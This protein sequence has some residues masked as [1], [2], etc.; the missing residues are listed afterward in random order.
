MG[1]PP[2]T[3]PRPRGLQALALILP[4]AARHR[5]VDCLPVGVVVRR[6]GEEGV[7]ERLRRR[8]PNASVDPHVVNTFVVTAPSFPSRRGL[9]L[10]LDFAKDSRHELRGECLRD[11]SVVEGLSQRRHLSVHAHAR[12]E[13]NLDAQGFKGAARGDRRGRARLAHAVPEERGEDGERRGDERG[14]EPGSD[15]LIGGEGTGIGVGVFRYVVLR[16][17]VER[18]DVR[19]ELSALI[20]ER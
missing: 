1:L 5:V 13:L 11:C 19:Q 10:I 14:V 4:G 20:L 15:N 16:H 8:H 6:G 17:G 9:I 2:Q 18:L 12:P 7:D 3:R